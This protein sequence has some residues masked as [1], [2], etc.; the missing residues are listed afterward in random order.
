MERNTNMVDIKTLKRG[1]TL[2]VNDQGTAKNVRVT[3]VG[4]DAI[5][6]PKVRVTDGITSW[7]LS[8]VNIYW[9]T[10]LK[11]PNEKPSL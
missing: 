8:E 1:Q 6:E 5:G 7:R 4:K 3:S 10:P 2:L 9:L 11:D